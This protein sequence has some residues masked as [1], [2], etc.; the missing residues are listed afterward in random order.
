MVKKTPKKKKTKKKTPKKNKIVSSEKGHIA[1]N[2]SNEMKERI[3]SVKSIEES[4]KIAEEFISLSGEENFVESLKKGGF[5]P[6]TYKI[7]KVLLNCYTRVLH[8]QHPNLFVASGNKYFLF[9]YFFIL[10]FFYFYFFL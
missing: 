10:Q 7:S 4:N 9:F 5:P 3:L 6:S 1:Q 8:S 2:Y